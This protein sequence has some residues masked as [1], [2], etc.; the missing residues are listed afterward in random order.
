MSDVIVRDNAV[1]DLPFALPYASDRPAYRPDIDGLRA[2]AV[3]SVVLCHA[4]LGIP[5]GFVGVDVF[6]VISGYLITGLILRDLHQGTFSMFTFWER[7]ARRIVPALFAVAVATST[8][9]WFLLFPDELRAFGST[10]AAAAVGASNVQ[11]WREAGYFDTAA[12]YKLMLHTWS[13]AVEEQFYLVTPVVL[14][15]LYRKVIPNRLLMI[16]CAGAA[17]S[18]AASV[19]GTRWFPSWTFYMLPTRA[20]E[21][22]LGSILSLLPALTGTRKREVLAA[23][24]ALGIFAPC[25]FY[26]ESTPFP[27][28]AALPVA[29]GTAGI[30]WAGTTSTQGQT[31]IGKILELRGL[32]GIGLISY[33]LYLWHWPLLVF[34]HHFGELSLI[35]RLTIVIASLVVATLSWRFIERPFRRRTMLPKRTYLFA[36]AIGSLLLLVIVGLLARVLHG[37][38]SRFAGEE[39]R[40]LDMARVDMRYVHEV[41]TRDIA[42]RL[43]RVG[44]PT[45]SPRMLIWGDSHAMAF[46]P[47]IDS[48]TRNLGVG[49]LVATH[50]ANPPILDFVYYI[51]NGF[52]E[53]SIAFNKA[54]IQ[55]TIQGDVE[56][57][58]LA[59]KWGLYARDSRFLG[60]LHETIA[61]L[62]AGGIQVVFV[63]DVPHFPFYVPQRLFVAE[64]FSSKIGTLSLNADA[65]IAQR[66]P[67]D[68]IVASLEGKGVEVIDPWPVFRR[69]STDGRFPAGDAGGV[70]YR[71]DDHLSTY[72]ALMLTPQFEDAFKRLGLAQTPTVPTR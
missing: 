16:L 2:I 58:V 42:E 27:G 56:V 28:L 35:E 64:R 3:M 66:R 59:G 15:L 30:I 20:W 17:A 41:D 10:L 49:A 19:I 67:Q 63:L 5:G 52:N 54:V 38:P 69:E 55:R 70:F 32:V 6:F 8:L 34:G 31:W 4:K 9:A 68:A 65:L 25:L 18:F 71:D 7:R 26:N 62:Q 22:L 39:K 14:W 46:L 44:T 11:L 51:P 13:L 23:C 60:R 47:A 48:A 72:G 53:K 50:S 29:L 21:L 45:E 61:A 36:A 43:P 24:G 12:Q 57:V 37:V 1:P 40:F 33:S